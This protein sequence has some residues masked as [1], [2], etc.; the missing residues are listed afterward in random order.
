[1]PTRDEIPATQWI[2]W[3]GATGTACLL[4]STFIFTNFQ[5]KAEAK[6]SQD[7]VQGWMQSIERRL[8]RIEEKLDKMQLGID[9]GPYSRSK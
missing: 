1:M 6:A 8:E 9:S 2:A 4:L 3:V 7:S 5:T